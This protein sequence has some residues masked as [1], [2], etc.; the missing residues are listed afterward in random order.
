MDEQS[1]IGGNDPRDLPD[2]QVLQSEIAKLQYGRQRV[3]W[4][5]A[6]ECCLQL[7]KQNGLELQTAAWYTLVR[8]KCAG[9]RV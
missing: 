9:I 7:A 1:F 5:L 2:F 6:E 4:S 8:T 3:N